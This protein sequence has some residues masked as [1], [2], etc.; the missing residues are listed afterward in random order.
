MSVGLA[1]ELKEEVEK[2]DIPKKDKEYVSEIINDLNS[3]QEKINHH[4]KRTSSI[5]KGML[6]HSRAST[7]EREPTDINKSAD[8]YLRLSYHGLRA[9]D[10]NF[11]ADYK[12][13]FD[14]TLPKLNVVPQDIGRVI[15]NLINNAFWAVNEKSKQNL[16]NY[17]PLVSV[18]TKKI[19]NKIEIIVK[20]NG[21]GIPDKIKDKIF[22]PFFTTKP[23]G[24]GTGLGLSL[25]YDIITKGQGGE[26]KIHSDDGECSEFIINLPIK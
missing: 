13:Y 20:D 10:K 17:V 23:T 2:F 11:N 26:I 5:V 12:T 3:N 6:E 8:E 25:A 16:E 14:E 18:Y 9:K 1:Q 22:H 7:G 24:E 4:G 15:L 19:G 21:N